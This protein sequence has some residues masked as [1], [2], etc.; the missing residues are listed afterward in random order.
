[1]HLI[2][3]QTISPGAVKAGV[4]TLAIEPA[5]DFF[6]GGVKPKIRLTGRWLERAGF[7]PGHRVEVCVDRPGTI[8]LRFLG[9][10][11]ATVTP[12]P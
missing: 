9:E 2:G 5:G 10:T 1:M 12:N 4:R 7:K 3:N 8:T 11:P 6:Y